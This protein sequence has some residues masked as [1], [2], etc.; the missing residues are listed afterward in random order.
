MSVRAISRLSLPLLNA[1]DTTLFPD[2]VSADIHDPEN[3]LASFQNIRAVLKE[4]TLTTVQFF[5]NKS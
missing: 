3:K 4:K 5:I 1:T 2:D